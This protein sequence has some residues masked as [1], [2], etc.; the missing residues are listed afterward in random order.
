MNR[1]VALVC[2]VVALV[3]AA[4]SQGQHGADNAPVAR[5]GDE[6]I[7]EAE[8]QQALAAMRPVD[9]DH[10]LDLRGEAVNALID[11]RLLSRAAR[12]EKLD[13]APE[14]RLAIDAAARRILNEA[15]L[16]RRYKDLKPPSAAEIDEYYYSHPELFA[17]RRIY[18][19]QDVSLV[20]PVQRLGEVESRIKQSR[21]LGEF[22]AWLKMQGIASHTHE[23]VRPAEQIAKPLLEQLKA[24][25]N[26]QVI[27][28]VRGKNRIRIVHLVSSEPRP[29]SPEEARGAIVDVLAERARKARL[30]SEI[31]VLR[32]DEKIEYVQGFSPVIADPARAG[33]VNVSAD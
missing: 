18:H 21:D 28:E 3:T 29:L 11:E 19:M 14:V 31:A 10:A 24:L 23:K 7:S 30:A 2:T 20:L 22:Q 1:A 27:V 26:G 4:C 33:P 6:T 16:A 9:A 15:Y 5:V 32:R 25:Q 12:A 13:E 8:L 17:K